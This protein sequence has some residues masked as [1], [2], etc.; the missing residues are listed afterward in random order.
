MKVKNQKFWPRLSL[1]LILWFSVSSVTLLIWQMLVIQERSAIERKITL[2]AANTTEVI[3]KQ[4]QTRILSLTRMAQRWELRGGT[5][6]GEWEVDVSN[7]LIDYPGSQGIA[8]A[9][10]TFRI[11]WLIPVT[12]NEKFQNINLVTQEGGETAIDAVFK[13][14]KVTMTKVINLIQ[15][16][17]G[18][19]VYVPLFHES[20]ESILKPKTDDIATPKS[21]NGLFVGIF[22]T[23]SLLEKIVLKNVTQ[24]YDI[25]VFEDDKEIYRRYQQDINSQSLENKWS[26]S[27]KLNLYGA[28]WK[29]K[30]WATPTLLQKEQSPLPTVILVGGL[31][32][33]ILLGLLAYLTQASQRYAKL[34]HLVNR[35]LTKQEE[36]WS[37]VLR[38]NN[39]GIWDWNIKTNEVFYSARWKKMLGYQENEI[40]N[41][42]SEWLKRVH[43]EELPW[44][45]ESIKNYLEKKVPSYKIEYRI[46]CKDGSYKWILSRGQALWNEAGKPLRMVGSHSD[47]SER[48]EIE[49]LKD[50]FVSVVS[51]EL[52]T[53]LTSISASLDLLASGILKNQP[54]EA[55]KMLHIAANNSERLIRLVND[56]LDIERIQSGQVKMTKTICHGEDLISSTVETMKEMAEKNGITLCREIFIDYT[57][58]T[59]IQIKNSNITNTSTTNKTKI[60]NRDTQNL[61]PTP[62]H[63]WAD[64]DR[65]I[66]VLTNLLSNA[67]KFSPP[68]TIVWLKGEIVPEK[69]QEMQ[70]EKYTKYFLFQ[71]KDQGR[72]IPENK[73]K[74]IFERF[75]Q[76]DASDSRTKG[77]TGLGLAICRSI[78]ENHQGK[79]WVESKLGEG[80]TFFFTIPLHEN[81]YDK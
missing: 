3:E 75:Q 10:S 70:E 64:P 57:D 80:S 23:Q 62:Y 12:T 24:E 42:R 15:G 38:G 27:K 5:P 40:A 28:Q 16:E 4:I 67:I 22:R 54:Q 76:V 51:H 39:D 49:R 53:P 50:E 30:V 68:G 60:I 58:N 34:L 77:G 69:K 44:V 43:P 26:E 79:I 63:L 13:H 29:V 6:R 66:Q 48:R 14:R 33:G 19:L 31:G 2:A 56:I 71:I 61:K 21:F 72:G 81:Y 7:Y 25:A 41:N 74:S 59:E 8:W 45:E 47:I 37:L 11:Q 32:M 52:R 78:V 36:R 18:F 17:K 9:D 35:Q 65:I 20:A 1:P 55:Q 73:L 46:Q